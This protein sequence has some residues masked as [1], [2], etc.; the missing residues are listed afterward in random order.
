MTV[1]ETVWYWHKDKHIDQNNRIESPEIDLHIYGLWIFDKRAKLIQWMIGWFFKKW[2]LD[3]WV[4]VWRKNKMSLHLCPIPCVNVNLNQTSSLNVIAK[5]ITF[6]EEK[7]Q[8][9]N[10]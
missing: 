9:N 6:L 7:V 8:E 10:L 1:I 2:C 3:Y 4:S 5:N